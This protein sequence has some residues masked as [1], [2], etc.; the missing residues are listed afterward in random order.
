MLSPPPRKVPMKGAKKNVKSKPNGISASQLPSSW[1]RVDSQF[2]KSQSSP[3]KSPLS[4]RKGVRIDN[5]SHSSVPTP[6]RVPKPI[7]VP[8]PIS[9]PTPYNASSPIHYMPKF[10][11][12]FIEKTVDVKGNENCGFR[13][14]VEYM[15]LTE[16]SH[17]MVHRALIREVKDHRNNYTR[18]YRSKDRYNY[19]L[20]ELHPPE[21]RSGIA[22][23]DKWLTLPKWVTMLQLITIGLWRSWQII[24]LE[25]QRLFSQLKVGHRLTQKPTSCALV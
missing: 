17:V 1:E 25:F 21:N 18:I 5:S 13:A 14:I 20:N 12:P 9:V 7:L 22:H 4:K 19:I 23:L 10:M 2:L 15:S 16:E 6:T 8:K 24:K 11:R 3:I